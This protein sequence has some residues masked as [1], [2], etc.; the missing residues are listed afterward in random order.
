VHDKQLTDKT[1]IRVETASGIIEPSCSTV[2]C[3]LPA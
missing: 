1:A 3:R 2:P